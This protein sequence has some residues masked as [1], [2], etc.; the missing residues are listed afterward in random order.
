M[1]AHPT[2]DV[3]WLDDC[4]SDDRAAILEAGRFVDRRFAASGIACVSLGMPDFRLRI[5]ARLSHGCRVLA[6]GTIAN[7]AQRIAALAAGA[8]EFLTTGPIDPIQMGARLQFMVTGTSIPLDLKIEPAER[9]LVVGGVS[10][11]LSERELVLCAALVAAQGGFVTHERL[12][13]LVWDNRYTDRQHLRVA[14]AR[15]RRRIEPEPDLPRYLLVEP[16][17]G[18]RIGS[19]LPAR[20]AP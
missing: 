13:E 6:L 7:K 10:H 2:F 19:G 8:H 15:L 5:S 16:A 9:T 14:I 17:I 4:S 18:Y 20:P 1:I 11:A 12:L 3:G